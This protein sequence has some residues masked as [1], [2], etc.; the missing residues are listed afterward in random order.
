LRA[1]ARAL[2]IDA[3]FFVAAATRH[4]AAIAFVYVA[5]ALAQLALTL[6]PPVKEPVEYAF[7]VHAFQAIPTIGIVLAYAIATACHVA[8]VRARSRTVARLLAT[9]PF[10]ISAAA[11]ALAFGPDRL[12]ERRGLAAIAFALPMLV[13]I[14]AV[15]LGARGSVRR[16]KEV[17]VAVNLFVAW[18]VFPAL[19]GRALGSDAGIGSASN[20][21]CFG[22][23]AATSSLGGLV[24]LV[25]RAPEHSTPSVATP[26]RK[27]HKAQIAAART[28]TL[29]LLI[30]VY[31]GFDLA[32]YVRTGAHVADTA[33][34]MLM[35]GEA[36]MALKKQLEEKPIGPER[37]E[38]RVSSLLVGLGPLTAPTVCEAGH[39]KMDIHFSTPEDAFDDTFELDIKDLDTKIA[40]SR[41]AMTSDA[42]YIGAREPKDAT[43]RELYIAIQDRLQA[44]TV[45]I[46]LIDLQLGADRARWALGAIAIA[47]L[48]L[49]RNRLGTALKDGGAS[50]DEPWLLL[51]TGDPF[52]RVVSTLY[53]AVVVA[54]SELVAA[55]LAMAAGPEPPTKALAFLFV[56]WA[57]GAWLS[58]SVAMRILKLRARRAA[59]PCVE[60]APV[61]TSPHDA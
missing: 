38:L 57:L 30:P 58:W 28:F 26:K 56:Q 55:A 21:A 42:T 17:L 5:L 18:A 20:V 54:A 23:V 19:L 36:M 11:C 15:A 4:R 24:W 35:R 59:L 50:D 25:F 41:L 52:E 16:V 1:V 31:L 32:R 61:V 14:A 37:T 60:P 40:K 45:H 44:R 33:N 9:P 8:F 7:V 47:I 53:F 3:R 2:S 22:L 34:K 29:V 6:A 10:L 13:A 43:H 49:V 51:D 12:Q 46:P 27:G 39:C 48:V